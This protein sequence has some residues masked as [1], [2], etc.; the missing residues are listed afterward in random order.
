MALKGRL[1]ELN[2]LEI[3]QIVAFAKKTGTLKIDGTLGSGAILFKDGVVLFAFSSSTT[4]IV[5]PLAGRTL[6]ESRAL[7]LGDEI[8]VALRELVSLREGSFEFQMSRETPTH[9]EGMDVRKFL[10]TEG[11]DPQELMLELARELDN[12]R[13]ESSSLLESAK[14]APKPRES[15]SPAALKPPLSEKA[16]TILLV[17]D[18]SQVLE[19][20]GDELQR[21]GGTVETAESA[22]EAIE[23]LGTLLSSDTS[24]ALVTDVAM[25]SS[26]GDSFEGGFEIIA[27]LKELRSDATAML[28]TESL[29]PA[30]RERARKLGVRKVAFKPALTKLDADEYESDLRSFAGVLIH[31]LDALLDG[32]G[33]GGGG[34][35]VPDLNHDVI[36]DFLRTMTEQLNRP[37]NGIARMILRVGSKYCER[38]VLFLIKGQTAKGLAGLRLGRAAKQSTEHAR[39]LS[40]D[41]QEFRPFAEVV[42]SRARVKVSY[43]TESLPPGIDADRAR[44]GLLLP[45]L[46]NHEVLS[47]LLCDNPNTGEPLGN[48]SG[49]SLFLSQA[50]M[51][52]ENASLHRKLRSFEN[53]FSLEDQG[54]LTQD[55]DPGERLE[56]MRGKS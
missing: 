51:A 31:E 50:G 26:S 36:F 43:E 32:D 24:I 4:P 39:T 35:S 37:S 7:L 33:G 46:H 27:R 16:V 47:I 34:V 13:N 6:D 41:L 20:V 11:V 12:A 30:A 54:P 2:L 3:L 15:P 49:L 21:A 14:P 9:F 53:R 28:M 1:E 52:M 18:E 5:A 44:E 19:I 10:V 22:G 25:P 55:L 48:L 23:R 42:Y 45:L 8:R 56:P 38:V 17:D 29:S 40:I